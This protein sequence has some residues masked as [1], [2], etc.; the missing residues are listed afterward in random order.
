LVPAKWA[1]WRRVGC[2]TGGGGGGTKP[3]GTSF[4]NEPEK[5]GKQKKMSEG[6]SPGG[7]HQLMG[8]NRE[9]GGHEN[10]KNKRL[11]QAREKITDVQEGPRTKPFREGYKGWVSY[12]EKKKERRPCHRYW[13]Q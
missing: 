5:Q 6:S 9:V 13:L 11:E 2:S 8:E 10:Q 1:K 3:N 7:V 4:P 12:I